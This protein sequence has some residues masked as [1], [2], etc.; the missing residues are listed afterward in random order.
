MIVPPGHFHAKENTVVDWRNTFTEIEAARPETAVVT[1]GAVEQ[2]GPHLPIGTDFLMAGVL[3]RGVAEAL[4]AYLLPV[5]PFSNSQEH[6]DFFGTVWLQPT[7]LRQVI[8]DVCRSLKHHGIRK[9][10]VIEGHGGN[11]ILKPTVREINL[12]DPEMTVIL[13]GPG[14]VTAKLQGSKIELHCTDTE[15]ARMMHAFGDLV[16]GRTEDFQPEVGREFLDYVGMRAVAPDGVWGRPSRA[17]AELG[18]R[19]IDDM[20]AMIVDYAR[21]TFAKIAEIK[22]NR[23]AP[24]A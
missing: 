12:N 9:I 19:S 23:G 8:H 2:H 16:K 1:V 20:I 18:R 10:L 11:W 15:T 5:L 22:A 13:F 21:E 24:D 7:T 6:Q 3:A 14:T 17:T 4:D